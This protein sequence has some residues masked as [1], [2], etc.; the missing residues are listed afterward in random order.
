MA[1]TAIVIDGILEPT[2][3]KRGYSVAIKIQQSEYTATKIVVWVVAVDSQFFI[4]RA[5]FAP[6]LDP[7]CYADKGANLFIR[8][9]TIAS[10]T[11]Q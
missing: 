11:L 3:D 2:L 5:C 9:S 4:W 1:G 6:F 7:G 8:R 10:G